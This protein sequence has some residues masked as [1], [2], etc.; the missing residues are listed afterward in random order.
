MS[1]P[2]GTDFS[3]SLHSQLDQLGLTEEAGDRRASESFRAGFTALA[4]ELEEVGF[5]LAFEVIGITGD[6]VRFTLTKACDGEPIG[7][8]DMT[9]D[10]VFA[11]PRS[12]TRA[13]PR[14][15]SWAT[16]LTRDLRRA[17]LL[18]QQARQVQP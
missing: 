5:G 3:E 17:D 6:L 11:D 13:I 2:T 8:T 10:D 7:A 14:L 12:G 9:L 4:D 1:T 15:R 18:R 16:R